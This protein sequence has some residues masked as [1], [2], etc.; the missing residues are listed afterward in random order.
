VILPNNTNY[1]VPVGKNFYIQSGTSMVIVDGDTLRNFQ[2]VGGTESKTFLGTSENN[3]VSSIYGSLI[4]FLVDKTVDWKTIDLDL[5]SFT[6]PA[7]KQ[8]VIVNSMSYSYV[9]AI[10]VCQPLVNGNQLVYL[11]SLT[12]VILDEGDIIS[13]TG[14]TSTNPEAR[15]VIN[16]YLKDK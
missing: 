13:T 14:C 6:V 9:N 16:G 2:G 7:N 8:F 15:Y 5:T 3:I 10:P 12:N 1:T 11:T 4:G